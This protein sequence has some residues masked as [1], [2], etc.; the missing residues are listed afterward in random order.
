MLEAAHYDVLITEYKAPGIQGAILL[1]EA[2][3]QYPEMQVIL[4]SGIADALG[5]NE[6]NTG[7]HSVIQ[8]N[9]LEVVN[10]TRSVKRLMSRRGM[11]KPPAS[12]A[13]AR[14]EVRR[15]QG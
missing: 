11:R 13:A 10:L 6:C 1:Q 8:K 3:T 4:L 15:N 14:Q 7:A 2:R 9:A 12:V 5:L